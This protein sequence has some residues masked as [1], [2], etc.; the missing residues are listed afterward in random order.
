MNVSICRHC[1]SI[2]VGSP[3]S[4]RSLS[5]PLGAKALQRL[6][7]RGHVSG[8][9][10]VRCANVSFI[11]VDIILQSDVIFFFLFLWGPPNNLDPTRPFLWFPGDCFCWCLSDSHETD[12]TSVFPKKSHRF[13]SRF[14]R[15]WPVS[16]SSWICESQRPL[17]QDVKIYVIYIYLLNFLFV[18]ISSFYFEVFQNFVLDVLKL[19]KDW[20]HQNLIGLGCPGAVQ[21]SLGLRQLDLRAGRI[22]G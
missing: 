16:H 3:R 19:G 13:F 22:D 21:S 6:P 7:I 15:S 12:E 18:F 4:L 20:N 11:S 17:W 2:W 5:M 14:P 1:M 8:P 9:R 10:H